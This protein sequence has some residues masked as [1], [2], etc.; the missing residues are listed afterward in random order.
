MN[1]KGSESE[2]LKAIDDITLGQTGYVWITNY[3]GICVT[4]KNKDLVGTSLLGAT[5]ANG[6]LFIKEALDN[7]KL[8]SGNNI[9]FVE[10]AWQNPG[11]DHARDKLVGVLNVPG[12]Q[13][14]VGI[15]TYNDELVDTEFEHK[16]LEEIKNKFAEIVVGQTGYAAVLDGN[17]NYVVSKNRATDGKNIM[18]AKD[19][20]DKEFVKEVI[21]NAIANGKGK[22]GTVYYDWK[23]TGETFARLKVG[24]YT[25]VEELDW[26]IWP[27]VY[28]E[29]FLHGLDKIRNDTIWVVI[30]SIIIGAILA[31]LIANFIATPIGKIQ[32]IVGEVSKGDLTNRAKIESPIL[33][34]SNMKNDFN[35]MI[36]NVSSLISKISETANNAAST[37]EELSASSEEVNSSTQQ[38]SA[39]VQ[40]IAK[41]GQS[42]SKAANDMKEQVNTLATEIDNVNNAAQETTRYA[43]DANSA[44]IKGKD[45]ANSAGSKM[46]MI[47]DAV[48]ESSNVVRILGD[49]SAEITKVIEVINSISE[50]TN[51]LALNAAIEAARAGEAGRGFAVVADEVRKL[52]EESQKATK[53]IEDM[54]REITSSVENAVASMET[55]TKSVE[56]GSEVVNEALTSLNTISQTVN[57]VHEQVKRINSAAESQKSA[58]E[59]VQNAVNEVSS[60]AEESAAS[61]EEVSASVEETTSSM[62]QVATAAQ[63]LA[64]NA[65]D[66]KRI[67]GTFKV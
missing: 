67:V 15:G 53:Q 39:T 1:W 28:Q 45:A 2:L 38:V 65:E 13:W 60:V 24:G 61:S 8:V 63:T 6:K 3:E 34:V 27:N 40:E 21:T 44:A 20:N 56:E 37:A 62:Q 29:E 11:E 26:I 10:Y 25:Y 5:D 32:K 54:I 51:L 42:L 22:T 48:K 58:S 31:Y 55:G 57:N 4:T 35:S 16:K 30:I 19:A 7:G 43:E 14:I 50:Q 49:K 46:Q 59:T 12:R 36:D 9:A 47:S 33:E 41:G 64:K 23:N 18:A 66:L 52:A 17:G